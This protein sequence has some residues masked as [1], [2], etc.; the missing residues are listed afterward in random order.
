MYT[1]IY[2]CIYDIYAYPYMR[3]IYMHICQKI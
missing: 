1:Y 3:N 2:V